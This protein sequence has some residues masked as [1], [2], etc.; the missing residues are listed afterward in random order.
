MCGDRCC[1]DH[2]VVT[3]CH[4]WEVKPEYTHHALFLMGV[5]TQVRERCGRAR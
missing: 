1:C 3:N 5:L 2:F 4:I